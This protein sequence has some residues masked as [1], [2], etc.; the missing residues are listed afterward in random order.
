M[1]G[2]AEAFKILVAELED[3]GDIGINGIMTLRFILG[4]FTVTQRTRV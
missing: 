4:I 2:K 3:F 1:H